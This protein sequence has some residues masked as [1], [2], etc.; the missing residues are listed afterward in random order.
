MAS[1]LRWTALTIATWRWQKI[2]KRGAQLKNI[3]AISLVAIASGLSTAAI[4]AAEFGNA[5][6]AKAMLE[7]AIS[8]VK[9]DKSTALGQIAKGENGF[10]DRDLYPFCGGPDGTFSAHPTL[11]GKSMKDLMS[12]T[13]E[14]VGAKLYEAAKDGSISEVSYLWPRPGSAEPV[15]KYSYVT[16]IGDQVCAVGYYK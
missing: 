2:D 4:S 14:P 5:A 7:K 12:K 13:G 3:I 16:K 8:A 11:T 10:R 15:Q 6:E 9:A 1:I